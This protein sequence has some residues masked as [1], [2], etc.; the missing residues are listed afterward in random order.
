[1][2]SRLVEEGYRP[3]GDVSAFHTG[4]V[5]PTGP[6]HNTTSETAAAQ[7]VRVQLQPELTSPHKRFPAPPF[8]QIS[9]PPIGAR[10]VVVR[11]LAAQ[12]AGCIDS[13]SPRQPAQ[14]EQFDMRS[15]KLKSMA[16]GGGRGVGLTAGPET[17]CGRLNRGCNP[18]CD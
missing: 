17:R 14:P 1:M 4:F 15:P 16:P 9:L 18:G 5:H 7:L 3:S 10:N 11:V 2:G 8:D 12:Y 13:L 6:V